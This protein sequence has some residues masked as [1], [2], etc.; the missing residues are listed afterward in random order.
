MSFDGALFDE[1][2]PGEAANVAF[3]LRTVAVVSKAR[4]VIFRHRAKPAQVSECPNLRFAKRVCPVSTAIDRN[5]AVETA[6][7][8]TGTR[9]PFA[10]RLALLSV[11]LRRPTGL[12]NQVGAGFPV[13]SDWDCE[14]GNAIGTV[15][16]ETPFG[17]L[18][19]E[20]GDRLRVTYRL[21]N[22]GL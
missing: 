12:L 10:F 20:N 22:P 6:A 1:A 3:H 19:R 7:G 13:P 21:K 9:S 17:S 4:K 16:E 14:V 15:H 5:R 8:P 11:P 2:L 18:W